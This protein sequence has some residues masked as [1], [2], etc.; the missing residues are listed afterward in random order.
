MFIDTIQR[1]SFD[2]WCD[3]NDITREA[4]YVYLTEDG[5]ISLIHYVKILPYL[6]SISVLL[7]LQFRHRQYCHPRDMRHYQYSIQVLNE[8]R[9]PF[10]PP[11]LRETC[12]YQFLGLEP[13]VVTKPQDTS[14]VK[15]KLLSEKVKHRAKRTKLFSFLPQNVESPWRTE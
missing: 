5:L 15:K 14:Q 8:N 11:R 1:T 4:V 10:A 7:S 3:E 12:F 2:C 13:E 9:I 6:Q